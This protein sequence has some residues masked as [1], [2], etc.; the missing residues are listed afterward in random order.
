MR[1][2]RFPP[3]Y[4]TSACP[5]FI[6]ISQ[7]DEGGVDSA[8][9]E[10]GGSVVEYDVSQI[11]RFDNVHYVGRTMFEVCFDSCPMMTMHSL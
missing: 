10:L 5:P 2:E 8:D 9:D 6:N 11:M 1:I 7:P 3:N 4:Q